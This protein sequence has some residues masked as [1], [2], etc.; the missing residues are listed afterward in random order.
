[1]ASD[2]ETRAQ[3]TCFLHELERRTSL[4]PEQMSEVLQEILWLHRRRKRYER[5]GD[6]F[7]RSVISMLVGSFFVGLGWA[8]VHLIKEIARGH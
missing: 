1:M 4:T 2:E 5:W 8:I 6:W 3:V 7:A